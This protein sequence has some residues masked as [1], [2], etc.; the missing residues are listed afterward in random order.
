MWMLCGALSVFFTGITLYLTLREKNGADWASVCSLSF[1]AITLLLEYKMAVDWVC[2]EDW[3][4]LLDVMP[5]MFSVLA[6][7]VIIQ[8][9]LNAIALGIRRKRRSAG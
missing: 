4:A 7:Y 8:I 3:T 2:R 6:G 1:T 5:T 9:L